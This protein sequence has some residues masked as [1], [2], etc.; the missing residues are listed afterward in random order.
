MRL[1]PILNHGEADFQ[2]KELPN[3]NVTFFLEKSLL[4]F[5]CYFAYVHL[6]ASQ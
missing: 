6:Y 4:K 5:I 1:I 2:Q 3:I